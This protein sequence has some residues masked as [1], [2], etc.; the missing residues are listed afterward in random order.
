MPL[1][2]CEAASGAGPFPCPVCPA[3]P[4]PTELQD[5]ERISRQAGCWARLPAVTTKP[6]EPR[7]A[8]IKTLNIP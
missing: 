3:L 7:T 8:E 6:L 4:C 1:P 5:T 2:P